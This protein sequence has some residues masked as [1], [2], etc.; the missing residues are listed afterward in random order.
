MTQDGPLAPSSLSIFLV[1][2][3]FILAACLHPQEF[4]CLP[5]GIIYYITIPAMYLLLV[6]YSIFN[7]VIFGKIRSQPETEIIKNRIFKT[8]RTI[9]YSFFSF[10]YTNKSKIKLVQP[11][12]T[13][14]G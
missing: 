9:G 13:A 11:I 6:I 4:W 12:N 1:G 7:L 10:I 5:H 8:L 2:G 3:S 14:K